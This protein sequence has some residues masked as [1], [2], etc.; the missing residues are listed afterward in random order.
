MTDP[1]L[2]ILGLAIV[3]GLGAIL[4][5]LMRPKPPVIDTAAD[6]RMAALNSRLDGMAT[7]LQTAGYHTVMMGKY[8]NRYEPERDGVP[9]G[10][11]EW[12]VGGNA[13]VGYNYVLNENGRAV[14]Y[15]DEPEDYLNNVLTEKAVQ[16]I[17]AA[18]AS[19]QPFFLYVLPYTPH[20]PSTAAPRHEG[21]FADA[22]LPRTPAF[23]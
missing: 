14:A 15:G 8:L 21:M 22:Q 7:W 3:A 11:D 13:Y 1:L 9:P 17:R 16:T 6:Q 12:Y 23:D 4:V 19:A 18:S 2:L 10:W 20:S 5:V